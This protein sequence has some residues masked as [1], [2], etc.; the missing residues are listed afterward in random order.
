ML[1]LKNRAPTN[2]L[3]P[4]K[5]TVFNNPSK[6]STSTPIAFTSSI[7]TMIMSDSISSSDYFN[8]PAFL[9]FLILSFAIFVTFNFG[10]RF[11]F[12]GHVVR[13][14]DNLLLKFPPLELNSSNNTI[15]TICQ[16]E[17]EVG[18]IVRVMP[19]CRHIFHPSC[20]DTWLKQKA[21][22]PNC[23]AA[24]ALSA[25]ASQQPRHESTLGFLDM[26]LLDDDL[27]LFHPAS[28]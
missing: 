10:S 24:T 19:H 13:R 21:S 8:L 5:F 7:A 28:C 17:Y 12:K 9:L 26:I 4:L 27:W 22:C 14:H 6:I 15:C 11:G 16:S 23:R 2:G 18:E 1:E 25:T 3:L 20:V